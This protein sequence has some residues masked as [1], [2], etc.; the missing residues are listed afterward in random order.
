M[1]NE[2]KVLVNTS[3]FKSSEQDPVT[4]MINQLIDLLKVENENLIFKIL[5][6]MNRSEKKISKKEFYD[7]HSFRYF[8][9]TKYQ[10]LSIKGIVPSIEKN[11]LNL[12]K[13][14]FFVIAQFFSLLKICF[15]FKPDVIY[16]HWFLP[17]VINTYLIS[18]LFK[19]KFIFTSHGSDVLLLNNYLGKFGSRIIKK[20]TKSSYKYSAVSN[21]VLNEINKNI[22]ID[23]SNE[24][25]FTVIPMG[26]DD[27]FFNLNETAKEISDKKKFLFIGRLVDIKGI[28]ILLKALSKYKI[29]NEN[30]E[31][32]ILGSGTE[33]TRLKN[34]SKQLGLS[35]NVNFLGF[36]N[37]DEKIKYI[38]NCDYFF[39]PSIKKSGQIEG[40]PLTLI[41]GM[42][43][44]KICIVS[45]SIGFMEHCDEKNSII[46]ESGNPE[47]L[48]KAILFADNLSNDEKSQMSIEASSLS[49]KF[50]FKEIA[51][52]HNDFFFAEE[53]K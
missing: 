46:F 22:N 39:V 18:K 24:K 5:K 37:F 50:S 52:K 29:D 20:I 31:L 27:K 10:D 26:I 2:I 3:N 40:G 44:G 15:L 19:T 16:C 12:I 28:D 9:P 1:G 6:P 21:L 32:N 48:Y 34:I 38:E 23:N 43:F 30:F 41:E 7:I 25:K 8:F 4:D 13:V 11:K 47:S 36:K 45:D 42:S 35:N 49:K 53:L 33:E 14:I 51:K 17:Q